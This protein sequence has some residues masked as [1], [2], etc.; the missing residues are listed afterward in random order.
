MIKKYKNM[1][2]ILKISMAFV[3][4]ISLL[5]KYKNTTDWEEKVKGFH[6]EHL[7]YFDS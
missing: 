5:S 1:R 4:E 2:S 6:Q 3:Y 7:N